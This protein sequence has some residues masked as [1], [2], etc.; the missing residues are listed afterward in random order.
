MA[1]NE[2]TQ[3]APRYRVQ[4]LYGE[5]GQVAA[6]FLDDEFHQYSDTWEHA[7]ANPGF[8]E[9]IDR[10]VATER[11][12]D[13]PLEHLAALAPNARVRA[14]FL[15]W[16]HV[17]D[18]QLDPWT[19]GGAIHFR[20]HWARA[21]MLAL[22]MGDAAGLPDADLDA[23]AA[24]AVFHDSRRKNP[25]L[26]TGHGDRAAHY[27]ADFCAAVAQAAAREEQPA[28][29]VPA[30][31]PRTYLAMQ[32]H[33]RDDDTGLQVIAEALE[34]DELPTASGSRAARKPPATPS[35][36]FHGFA[37]AG[38]LVPDGLAAALPAGADADAATIYRMFKDADGLDRIRL[39]THGLD[40]HFLRLQ[41]AHDALPLAHILLEESEHP[42]SQL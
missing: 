16:L 6:H 9:I 33:D 7:M 3:R 15:R 1:N 24:A 11:V 2:N 19:T 20:P 17:I 31:D 37:Q 21:L 27:Y 41:Y 4:R 34:R 30:F 14:R 22:T 28:D 29:T 18:R 32:W 23:L 5:N 42:G 13:A 12:A 36:A 35:D 38:L 25:Y 39:G 8:A 26:D 40:P 10:D